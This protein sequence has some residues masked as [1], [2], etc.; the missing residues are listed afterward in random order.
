[1]RNSSHSHQT[2]TTWTL[3]NVSVIDEE[4]PMRVWNSRKKITEICHHQW[5]HRLVGMKSAAAV[6]I[7]FHRL[8]QFVIDHLHTRL[9]NSNW[10]N[11]QTSVSVSCRLIRHLMKLTSL[12]L[13]A[14]SCRWLLGETISLCHFFFVW[15]L[16]SVSPMSCCSLWTF[17][18]RKKNA[19]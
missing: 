3:W 12:A 2:M 16:G 5:A 9:T 7:K 13:F 10:D 15:K 4:Y 19:N 18:W 14:W 8:G 11:R 17:R 1:M 6:S